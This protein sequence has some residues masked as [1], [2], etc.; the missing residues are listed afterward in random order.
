MNVHDLKQFPCHTDNLQINTLY[1]YK[2]FDFELSS[3]IDR[4]VSSGHGSAGFELY[5]FILCICLFEATYTLIIEGHKYIF[6]IYRLLNIL[7]L[8][9][10]LIVRY[11]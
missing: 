6:L 2:I 8:I 10:I 7:K 5:A 9:I 11:F 1:V 4:M 3:L